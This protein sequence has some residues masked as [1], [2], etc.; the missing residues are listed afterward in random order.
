[1]ASF[2]PHE[3]EYI[4]DKLVGSHSPKETTNNK[5]FMELGALAVDVIRYND[6]RNTFRGERLERQSF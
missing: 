4:L 6:P 2:S 5:I 1:M 3:V